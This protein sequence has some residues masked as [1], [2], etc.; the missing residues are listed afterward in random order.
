MGEEVIGE[1][2]LSFSKGKGYFALYS[3]PEELDE[4]FAPTGYKYYVDV[5]DDM[6]KYFKTEQDAA[7]WIQKVL[8]LQEHELYHTF[9]PSENMDTFSDSDELTSQHPR[10]VVWRLK[11]IISL[12][13]KFKSIEKEKIISVVFKIM[14]RNES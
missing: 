3:I 9:I 5:N 7:L 8:S 13:E 1:K 11:Q 2:L 6:V 12:L 10:V 14:E 4:I